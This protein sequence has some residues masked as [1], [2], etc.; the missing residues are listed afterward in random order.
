M[1]KSS[2]KSRFAI[3]VLVSVLKGLLS[4]VTVLVLARG[5]GPALYGDF[6]FLL[7]SFIAF[8][9]LLSLGTSN[10]FYTFMSQKPRGGKFLA[11]YGGWQ[12]IQFFLMILFIGVFSPDEWIKNIWL[13]QKRELIL[14]SF[15]AVFMQQQA[16]HVMVH[17]GESTRLTYRVQMMNLVIA[18]IH[19]LIVVG[20]WVGDLLTLKFLF[21]IIVCEYI[22][23]ILVA[24]KLLKVFGL[25]IE[26]FD[27][28]KIFN[29]YLIYCS[30]LVI[31][32]LLGFAHEFADRWLLQ[33]F[34]GSE[35]Q[36][37]YEVSYRF[38]TVSLLVATSIMNIFWKEFAEAK[39]NGSL[40]RM[41]TIY[42]KFS[43]F[44]FASG[45]IMSGFLIPWSN[46]IVRYLLGEPYMDG[47]PVLAIMLVFSIYAAV[48]QINGTLMYAANR[49]KEQLFIG[50][51][52]MVVSIPVSYF[53][54]APHNAMLPGLE[55]GAIGMAIKKVLLTLILANTV[56]WWIGRGYGWQFDWIYQLVNLAGTLLLGWVA[57]K[58]AVA[59]ISP[60]STNL[61]FSAGTALFI[62]IGMVGYM[63]WSFP[64]LAGLSRVEF[65]QY[66]KNPFKDSKTS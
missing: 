4:F 53:L 13:D 58:V 20:V 64:Q 65:S 22:F 41:R 10:A 16:W 12:L 59:L 3:S 46:E 60:I 51:I 19:L 2:I 11:V 63:F 23:A 21:A 38:C 7:G 34:G 6:A 8:K 43:R 62:Y 52:F 56:T 39:E 57:Q 28:R 1:P 30:P 36:G 24:L 54:Q 35:Q 50:A 5:L 66:L 37:L 40:E 26:P 29:E 27:G 42:T 61:F 17:I 18:I 48:G 45:A 55:L 49:T 25:P 32:S 33:R 47:V 44:L 14:L 15:V 31:Y 9:A